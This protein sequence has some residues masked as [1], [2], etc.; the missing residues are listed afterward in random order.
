MIFTITVIFQMTII[1]NINFNIAHPYCC[2]I[3]FVA[4]SRKPP[5]NN[6]VSFSFSWF[7]S[8]SSGKAPMLGLTLDQATCL[9]SWVIVY[10]ALPRRVN[11]LCSSSITFTVASQLR[12]SAHKQVRG[13]DMSRICFC[14][15]YKCFST[16]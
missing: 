16:P 10:E 15:L 8:V 11:V 13:P 1:V 5:P 6:V 4:L 14:R 2:S 7:T 9:L 12:R 3:L